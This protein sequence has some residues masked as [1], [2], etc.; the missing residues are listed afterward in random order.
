M[1]KDKKYRNLNIFLNVGTILFILLVWL[2][3]SIVINE[4]LII[5]TPLD[6]FKEV[7]NLFTSREFLINILFTLG[8][9]V[10]AFVLSFSL[11]LML[12]LLCKF[13]NISKSIVKVFVS[14]IRAMPT[15]AVILL[16]LLWTTSNI[17]AIIVTMLVLLPTMYSSMLTTLNKID[18][19]ILEMLGIYNVSKKDKFRKYIFP[20]VLPSMLNNIGSGLSLNIKLIVAAEV[21]ASTAKSIGNMMSEAKIYFE[22]STLFA[23]V[24]IMVVVSVFVELLFS[25]ISEKVGK[26]YASK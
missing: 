20:V 3:A 7:L 13:S 22:T 11:A 26:K 12:A 1:S 18:Y 9:S 5:P 19:E 8:R 10:I 4:S 25:K 6:S 23:L 24:L 14:I 15:I 21:I 17:A 16:L 2:I